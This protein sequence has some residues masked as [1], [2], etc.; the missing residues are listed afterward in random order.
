MTIACPE[1]LARPAAC[2]RRR[3][4]VPLSVSSR[5]RGLLKRNFGALNYN[6]RCVISDMPTTSQE[7]R[8]V[9]KGE[10]CIG[11]SQYHHGRDIFSHYTK[12]TYTKDLLYVTSVIEGGGKPWESRWCNG[13]WVNYVVP[14]ADE[15]QEGEGE[16]SSKIQTNCGCHIRKPP[17][18]ISCTNLKT[19]SNVIDRIWRRQSHSRKSTHM[20]A[21]SSDCSRVI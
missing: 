15:G 13:G 4:L 9:E 12:Y 11:K 3:P 2:L 7:E 21:T 6:E 5:M 8:K 17:Y 14:N 16:Y 18:E 1:N 10:K 20:R 19:T